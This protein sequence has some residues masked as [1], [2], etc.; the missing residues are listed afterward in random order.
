MKYLN[1]SGTR[2][3]TTEFNFQDLENRGFDLEENKWYL[4]M[5]DLIGYLLAPNIVTML[6]ASGYK[7]LADVPLHICFIISL[8][9]PKKTE[10]SFLSK[11]KRNLPKIMRCVNEDVSCCIHPK[12]LDNADLMLKIYKIYPY[13][14][15]NISDRLK[16]DMYFFNKIK[17]IHN[18][19]ESYLNNVFNIENESKT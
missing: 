10:K 11:L 19:T 5:M 2:K 17:K 18:G 9:D 15:Y 12:M 7:C 16:T 13:C 6:K 3:E 1:N 8:F 4:E 14:L